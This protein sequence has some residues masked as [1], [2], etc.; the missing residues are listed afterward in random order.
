MSFFFRFNV[1]AG[2]HFEKMA[3]ISSPDEEEELTF[4]QTIQLAY[5]G[6]VAG[7]WK[8]GKPFELSYDEYVDLVDQD[9]ETISNLFDAMNPDPDKKKVMKK[10]RKQDLGS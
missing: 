3:G 2:I 8:E 10:N 1:K 7:M 9:F 4:E 5:A 6:T